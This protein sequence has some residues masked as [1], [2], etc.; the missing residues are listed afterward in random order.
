MI[1]PFIKTAGTR[2]QD[3][4]P[5]QTVT[6]FPPVN[7]DWYFPTAGIFLPLQRTRNALLKRTTDVL[8]S[9]LLLLCFFPWLIPLIS[10]LIVLDSRGPVF[11][12]QQRNKR[13]GGVFRCIKFRT[14]FVNVEADLLPVCQ[15][16]E[17][18]TRVGK[19]LRRFH[20]DELP[21]LLNVFRGDMS[22]IG[23]RPHM[24]SDNRRFEV[25]VSNYDLR[26]AVK[27]GMTG[28]AQVAGWTGPVTNLA[29]LKER[30]EKD[31]YYVCQWS[32]LL[33]VKIACLTLKQICVGKKARQIRL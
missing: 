27:P 28:L 16:D 18:I 1:A 24:I 9:G 22:L 17:R 12:L 31:L 29:E 2:K 14:M 5:L 3:G 6:V 19:W 30:V 32:L 11:F 25:L 13:N 15:N 21:Q 20:L 10:L 4:L 26:H 33:D 7:N 23:P 8:L